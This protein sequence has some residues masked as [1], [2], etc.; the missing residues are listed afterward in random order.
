MPTSCLRSC[1]TCK[2]PLTLWLSTKLSLWL[3]D[4]SLTKLPLCCLC[5]WAAFV[6]ASCLP[7]LPTLPATFST[8]QADCR[9]YPPPG[10][11]RAALQSASQS[12]FY[13]GSYL[14]VPVTSSTSE[15][16]LIF[17]ITMFSYLQ[18]LRSTMTQN[19]LNNCTLP[20]VD[21]EVTHELIWHC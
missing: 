17:C 13:S 2:L 4:S 16:T 1:L 7:S 11:H 9:A 8:L 10:Y 12:W 20:H 6:T 18:Y 21:K 5:D 3:W 14:T 19:S 15:R